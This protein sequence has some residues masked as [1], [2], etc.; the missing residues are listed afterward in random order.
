MMAGKPGSG[1][2]RSAGRAGKSV[3]ESLNRS[4]I[5]G[6]KSVLHRYANI[7]STILNHN[8]NGGDIDELFINAARVSSMYT[9]IS[10]LLKKIL[11]KNLVAN[12]FIQQTTLYPCHQ[13]PKNLVS[14]KHWY[15]SDCAMV[16]I[17]SE[18]IINPQVWCIEYLCVVEKSISEKFFFPFKP[19]FAVQ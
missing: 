16:L 19:T 17:G 11:C 10:C 8:H 15:R 2:A 12:F 9:L 18:C 6:N 5:K 3:E 4:P 7:T 13:S 14:K 1:A